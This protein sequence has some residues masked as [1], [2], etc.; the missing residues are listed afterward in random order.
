[1]IRRARRG[2]LAGQ[3]ERLIVFS[4]MPPLENGIADY[5]AEL[6][7]RLAARFD[8]LVVIDD[9]VPTPMPH[10]GYGVLRLSEYLGEEADH[11]SALH[12]YQVGNN[13]DHAYLV[14]VLFR[15]PGVVVM[16]DVSLHH[17]IDQ[18]SLRYG[19]VTAYTELLE[20]EYGHAGRLLGRQ[21]EQHR[22]RGRS[23]FYELP[24][25]RKLLARAS[26]VVV[27]SLF[28]ATRVMAQQPDLPVAQV[29]HHLAESALAA[30]RSTSRQ[31]ARAALR[32]ADDEVF[33]VSLGFITKAK[34]IDTV[35]RYLATNRDRLPRFRYILAGQDQPENFDVQALISGLGLQDVAL[36]TGYL[37]EPG[38]YRHVLASDLVVN[39]RYPSGGETS[40]TLI[41][42]LGLG[43]CVLVNDIGPFAEYPDEVCAKVPMGGN[44]HAADFAS[45]MDR[46]LGSAPVRL[47]LGRAARE[48]MARTHTLQ[49]SAD[50]YTQL[51]RQYGRR[52]VLPTMSQEPPE[53]LTVH[54]REN[55][56]RAV[57]RAWLEQAPL[58]V[59]EGAVPL[60]RQGQTQRV[61]MLGASKRDGD[62]LARVFNHSRSAVET[63]PADAV[64]LRRLVGRRTHHIALVQLRADEAVEL[65]AL[66]LPAL[67]ALLCLHGHLLI[68]VRSLQTL[69][70][71][72][73]WGTRAQLEAAGFLVDLT[74]NGR[75]EL[76]FV[77]DAGRR[78]PHQAEG[79]QWL[80]RGLKASEFVSPRLALA[81]GDAQ[82]HPRSATA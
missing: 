72:L 69:P 2:L 58:W 28:A 57:P 15:R 21:F 12:L 51:L 43:A 4:P 9:H 78:G 7:P 64:T 17:L 75:A 48:Y 45:E 25:T 30:Q 33:I 29:H 74:A 53:Y 52:P 59:T 35:L 38:F 71:A 13:G 63:L 46:L 47:A 79:D 41:R 8:L 3:R 22:W 62:L 6:L 44:D 37:D 81:A 31:Q 40:G 73:R 42:A 10:A 76:S 34:Q 67:N 20:L 24:M 49:Q 16:H 32:L 70:N 14:P 54:Q 82:T 5:T 61:L 50:H 60:S 23:M 26:A 56:L 39:L 77:L 11:A 1:M 66:G 27:H 18:M 19:D 55:R 68:Y 36:I 80:L 65:L